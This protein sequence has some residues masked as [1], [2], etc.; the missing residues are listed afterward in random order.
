[1]FGDDTAFD[2]GHH[3][4]VLQGA[5]TVATLFVWFYGRVLFAPS[6][7]LRTFRYL[8]EG[9]AL[10]DAGILTLSA[11]AALAARPDPD[12]L[13]A[14]VAMA[15]VWGAIRVWFLWTHRRRS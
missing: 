9:M 3:Y 12:T 2:T 11:Y 4:L 7:D 5:S 10:G 13:I 6:I 15:S 14:Q 1:M 8:Q